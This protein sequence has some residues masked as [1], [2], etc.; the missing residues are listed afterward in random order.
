M[1]SK[2]TDSSVR[3]SL[4]LSFILLIAFFPIASAQQEGTTT[5]GEA[6]S[7]DETFNAEIGLSGL[8][9]HYMDYTGDAANQIAIGGDFMY[10]FHRLAH[11]NDFRTRASKAVLQFGPL[12]E[13]AME[14]HGLAAISL[15]AR[16]GIRF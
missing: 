11:N 3:V 16:L 2:G 8:Y 9:S 7:R 10:S 6:P 1:N 15:L 13:R 14:T 4:F 12:Y 5:D